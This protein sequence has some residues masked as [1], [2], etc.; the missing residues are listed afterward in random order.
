MSP[1]VLQLIALLVQTII[2]YAPTIYVD[3][4]DAVDVLTSGVDPTPEQQASIDVAL[5][6]ANQKLQAAIAAKTVTTVTT[7]PAPVD[8]TAAPT[9]TASSTT[10]VTTAS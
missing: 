4:K 6:A 2:Q 1:A 10:T 8:P 3:I 7:I 5:D 9:A